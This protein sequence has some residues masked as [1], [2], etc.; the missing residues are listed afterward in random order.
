MKTRYTTGEMAF[1]PKEFT[2]APERPVSWECEA[3]HD[4]LVGNEYV[5]PSE[6]VEV[7]VTLRFV[8]AAAVRMLALI[9]REVRQP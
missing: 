9:N 2:V 1:N 8:G 3:E 7:K 4:V 5:C 6:T